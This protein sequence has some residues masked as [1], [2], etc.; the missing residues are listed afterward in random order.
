MLVPGSARAIV[1]VVSPLPPA[2]AIPLPLAVSGP[3]IIGVVIMLACI[4]IW[5]LLRADAREAAEEPLEE[6]GEEH[7]HA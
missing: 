4:A 7:P 6:D 1:P 2:A 3:L 5:L